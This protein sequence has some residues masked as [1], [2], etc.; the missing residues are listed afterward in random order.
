M[1]V[2]PARLFRFISVSNHDI[3][4]PV[5]TPFSGRQGSFSDCLMFGTTDRVGTWKQEVLRYFNW[6][7]DTEAEAFYGN[8]VSS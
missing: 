7:S 6:V 4:R 5:R 1:V 2:Y 3:I 8:V